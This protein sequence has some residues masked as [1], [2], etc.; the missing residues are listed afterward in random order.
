MR[1][2]IFTLGVLL[3]MAGTAMACGHRTCSGVVAM[4]PARKV[5]YKT[6]AEAVRG[7]GMKIGVLT[8]VSLDRATPSLIYAHT[9]RMNH[10]RTLSEKPA[11]DQQ[12][13]SALL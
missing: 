1:R 5:A 7:K 4:Y 9:E 10:V 3:P 6:I 12:S 11:P 2:A 13:S 8:S